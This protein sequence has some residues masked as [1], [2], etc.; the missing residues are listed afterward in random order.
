M[1]RLFASLVVTIVLSAPVAQ[2]QNRAQARDSAL[3]PKSTEA[4]DTSLAGDLTRDSEELGS[5]PALEYDTFRLGVELQVADKRHA[6]IDSLQKIISYSSDEKEKPNLLFRLGELYWE[7]SRHFFFEANRKDDDAI[8]AQNAGDQAGV[9]RAE[10]E[11]K[12][13]LGEQ[14][15]HIG[16]ALDQYREIVQRYRDFERS[17]EVLFFLGNLMMEQG[18]QQAALK[19]YQRLITNHPKSNFIADAYLAFGEYYFNNSDGRPDWLKRALAAYERAA[20][21]PENQSYGYAIYKQGWTHFN[22]GD[23]AKAKDRFK[24][25]VLF[26]QLGGD[27]AVEQSG[28][29]ARGRSSLVREARADFVRAYSR[30]GD[31]MGARNEFAPLAQDDDQRFQ[32]MK[33]L[34][35]HY[36]ADGKDREAAITYH[37]LIQERPLSPEAPGF[38]GRIVDC[39]LRAGDKRRTVVQTRTLVKLL[40]DIES[41]GVIRTDADKK[42]MSEARDLAERTLSNLAVNWH[43]EGRKT[44]DDET[45]AH[46]NE[47]YKDY[48]ALFSDS[49][50]A[51][52]LRFFW[53]ELLS[54]NLQQYERAAVEYD[55][56]T[57]Q[58]IDRIE[59][60][61]KDSD[62][63]PLP[64]GKY[65]ANAA[66]NAV[67]SWDTVVT[68][69]KESGQ[70]KIERNGDAKS[71]IKAPLTEL[72]A[73]SERYVKYVPEG[74]KKVEILYKIAFIYYD[75][76]HLDEA[77]ERFKFIAQTY[78]EYE[79]DDG[80]RAAVLSANLV[81]D[82]YNIK[83]DYENVNA[84][85][86]TFYNDPKLARGAF[87][88]ELEQVIE[89][90][91]FKLVNQ[92]EA[93][94][95]WAKAAQAYLDFVEKFPKSS[96]A[97]QA[98][99]NAALDFYKAK[100]LDRAVEVR[101]HLIRNY[102]AS[103]YVPDA[104]YDNA[105]A[106]ATVGDFD[107][108]A[109]FYELYV[110]GYERANARP[111][112]ARRAARGRR[113]AAPAPAPRSEQVWAEER[114]QHALINAGVVREGLG[115][116]A[117]ARR[118]R[119]KYLE[120]WPRAAD[121]KEVFLSIGEIYE[122]QGAYSRALKHY[123][124]FQR[125]Y[126]RTPQDL[127]TGE[128][129]IL[130]L[131][132]DHLNRPRDVRRILG[133][134]VEYN[135]QLG[136]TARSRLT[137]EALDVLAR[138]SLHENEEVWR[139]YSGIRM[140]WGR[141]NQMV[142]AFRDGM[143]EKIRSRDL[144]ERAYTRTVEL[145]APGPAI[146]ALTR[147]GDASEQLFNALVD[148]PP[149][150]GLPE[151]AQFQV[152]A[153]LGEW[154]MPVAEKA[155][156][157]YALALS[158]A[159]EL[160]VNNDCTKQ[161]LAKLRL[162]RPMDYPTLAE[163]SAPMSSVA[164]VAALVTGGMLNEIQPL[165]DSAAA[166]AAARATAPIDGAA[167]RGQAQDAEETPSRRESRS[168]V[169]RSADPFADEPED[170]L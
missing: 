64:P 29:A 152:Q 73:S 27:A 126:G 2:A 112:P 147:I 97:E 143:Q 10:A 35:D 158:K 115:Q 30:L 146:C 153:Q 111:A 128:S 24:T 132:T 44:R 3:A 28:N 140:R 50:K 151:E 58:D 105:E 133:R 47:I 102:P 71:E 119:E 150:P 33:R 157:A 26:A 40:V 39:V 88:Q 122:A 94:K 18:E 54:D 16:L 136:R 14:K 167:I 7:E 78:P 89:Q 68:R 124:D 1:Q 91:A 129:R 109:E 51:Y 149:P 76:N 130:R 80:E 138:A 12:R 108:A 148:A 98:L 5:A 34:A 117:A 22:L 52:D 37:A 135:K 66:Y 96:I 113:A 164:Q 15:R 19:M 53:A 125:E 100:M 67:L 127:L 131:Y 154:A 142:T 42:A 65:L 20:A 101:R 155:A 116:H 4:L 38:Q 59:G 8:R 144:V 163:V 48:L 25:V 61:K 123:E 166:I 170:V 162:H 93:R 23:Y 21:F 141:G 31:V 107:A 36:Y 134:V 57:L 11:K 159:R 69:L 106:L 81:L 46:A 55:A 82:A 72:L 17:D 13:L 49:P 43:Q 139:N 79:F 90:S 156:E 85:A 41:S 145:G 56:V 63:N 45:F 137:G 60:R 84:W 74:S 77:I 9:R 120:L 168:T 104:V 169:P 83:E 165:P 110:R 32:M 121:A 75:H 86:L 87:R 62:G 160:E 92:M 161:A 95:E 114:A 6:Q 99:N 118:A 103:K 70:L